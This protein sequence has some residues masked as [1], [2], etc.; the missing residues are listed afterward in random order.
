MKTLP[1]ALDEIFSLPIRKLTL[2]NPAPGAA[3]RR[4]VLKPLLV[5]EQPVFQL[6]QF[7]D[8]QVFH[9]NL[10]L[11]DARQRT[12]EL[13]A[14]YRQLDCTAQG[15]L[16]CL[17]LSKKGKLFFSRQEAAQVPVSLGGHNRQKQYLLPEGTPVPPLI[18]L[19]VM[20]E[21]GRVVKAKYD[22][23]RQ[24]NRFVELIHDALAKDQAA[25]LRI[26]DFGCGKSYLTFI[27]YYYLTEI[28]H[29]KTE[30]TGMDL[31]ADV[32]RRCNAVA[33]KYG[34]T[35]LHFLC[36]DIR[37]Y[38]PETPPDMVITLHACDTATDYA[39]FHAIRWGAR[40]IFSCP[41]CQHELN[42]AMGD[43]LPPITGYGILKERFAALA[44]DAIRGKLLE[45]QGYHV[46]ILEFIDLAHSPKNLLIRAK[47]RNSPLTLRRKAQAE[48]EA[49]L[50]Q[51]GADQTLMQ[52]L[53][54]AASRPHDAPVDVQRL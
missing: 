40:Y 9:D 34:Y 47:K 17:K 32:I 25:V 37:D 23:F 29:R 8:T 31:K 24:I 30:I 41:C 52:L 28:L 43:P 5:R 14:E 27:L 42:S 19:G 1:Q 16:F 7:T 12:E 21:D 33:E 39:L 53:Q 35:H 20:T 6:E 50:T 38:Q 2:S 44:T 48:A 15:A 51:L 49:L 26:V 11:A 10:P 13:L 45:A 3:Y 18:D 46:Q 36:G 4:I 54:E 22:K